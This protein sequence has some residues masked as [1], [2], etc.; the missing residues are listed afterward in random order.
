MWRDKMRMVESAEANPQH[1][2]YIIKASAFVNP[3]EPF[4]PSYAFGEKPRRSTFVSA[5][6]STFGYSRGLEDSQA[7]CFEFLE[8]K[9]GFDYKHSIKNYLGVGGFS[10]LR[11]EEQQ[12][13]VDVVRN[14]NGQRGHA[15]GLKES[16]DET[17]GRY[18]DIYLKK[19]MEYKPVL[20]GVTKGKNLTTQEFLATLKVLIQR[21]EVTRLSDT[22]NLE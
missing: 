21:S 7:A 9:T 13:I 19:A 2:P 3:S 22:V 17:I 14:V 8:Q 4:D 6:I 12:R 15:K 16:N 5:A 1:L 11:P 10:I 18:F 20:D